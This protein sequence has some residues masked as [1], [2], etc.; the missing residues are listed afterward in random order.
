MALD[1][2]HRKEH[3]SYSR[4]VRL[5]LV[6]SVVGHALLFL[7]FGGQRLPPSPFAAAGERQRDARAAAGGGLEAV[8]LRPPELAMVEAV[9]VP[10]PSEELAEEEI[11]EPEP[12]VEEVVAVALGQAVDLAGPPG[13]GEERGLDDGVG[14]GDGGTQSEGLFRVVPPRPRGPDA[15][16]RRSPERRARAGDR[17]LGVRERRRAGGARLDAVVTAIG[18]PSLRPSAPGPRGRVGLRGGEPG[19]AAGGRVVPLHDH[20]VAE[21]GVADTCQVLS[22][23]HLTAASLVPPGGSCANRLCQRPG[24]PSH[25]RRDAS[26]RRSRGDRGRISD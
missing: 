16:A 8:E 14:E 4:A 3:R 15:A 22:Y 10:V 21:P 7:I 24:R 5:G 19:R 20:H 9:P 12:E 18:R 6:A 13:E 2:R 11:P 26:P 25:P 23:Q 17:G 1:E